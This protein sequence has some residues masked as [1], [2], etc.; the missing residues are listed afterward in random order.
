MKKQ[1]RPYQKTANNSIFD[2]YRQGQ[3]G[4][5]LVALP[6]GTGKA[7]C[8]AALISAIYN[9]RNTIKIIMATHNKELVFQNWEETVNY[10]DSLPLGVY[11]AG[12]NRKEVSQ[13]TYGSIQSMSSKV[14]LFGHIDLIVIDEAH[15][16][17]NKKDTAY[18]K[19][20]TALREVNPNLRVVGYTATPWRLGEGKLTDGD[21]FSD[22]TCD[23]T[24]GD[25]FLWFIEEGYLVDIVSK[26]TQ[27]VLDVSDVQIRGGEFV[28]SQ[29]QKA[30]DKQEI[31]YNALC[32]ALPYIN[33]FNSVIIFASGIEH[34]DHIAEMLNSEFD[35]P[36]ISVHSKIHE[37]LRDDAIE[38]YKSGD[39]K[40]IVNNNI[41]TTGFNHP[42]LDLMIDLS[43]TASS[44]L[45]VQ[46]NGRLTRPFY[47]KEFDLDEK[48]GRLASIKA[49]Q[50]PY[51][52]L[53][54][55]AGN[56]MRNGKINAPRIPRKKGDGGGG[57]APVKSCPACLTL[58]H[59]S[60]RICN[61]ENILTGVICEHEFEFKTKLTV[62]AANESVI[63]RNVEP[64]MDWF[65]VTS[66]SYAQKVSTKDK[67]T[68]MLVVTYQCAMNRFSE[69]VLLEHEG[70]AKSNAKK[71]WRQRQIDG[72]PPIPETVIEALEHSSKLLTPKMIYVETNT[73]Y[74]KIKEFAFE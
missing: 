71:W 19:F 1:L 47:A 60:R 56:I 58:H 62:E 69:Y 16:I 20:I 6:T 66:V 54:D 17:S 55:Y 31:T 57:E 4:N 41:L 15:R 33:A 51:A 42:E 22:I 43:P 48:E 64:V 2:Y 65:H 45:H 72:V 18:Q 30:V 9:K 26:A 14:S 23:L 28:P 36:A 70:F 40:V 63:K 24:V 3:T 52:M 73:K 29:L 34:S 12:L 35:I 21:L 5:P 10:D 39:Y 53:L 32:E 44:A 11:C 37:T 50:K 67:K 8:I 68:P 59:T 61:T 7:L 27:T 46:K 49:S 25:E 38:K 74:P 13:I